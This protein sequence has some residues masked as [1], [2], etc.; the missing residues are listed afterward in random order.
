MAVK[1]LTERDAGVRRRWTKCDGDWAVARDSRPGAGVNQLEDSLERERLGRT[2]ANP[3]V[4][5]PEL[6]R[7]TPAVL[8]C[9]SQT[10]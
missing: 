10:P 3:A 9:V 7:R 4:P 1:R 8:L 6:R 2:G 5:W